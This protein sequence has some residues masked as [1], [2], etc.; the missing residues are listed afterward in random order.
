VLAQAA[1]VISVQAATVQGKVCMMVLLA[2]LARVP[3][4]QTLIVRTVP[5][6]EVSGWM[7][8]SIKQPAVIID[9]DGTVSDSEHMHLHTAEISR[10]EW[11]WFEYLIRHAP[12][13]PFA[14]I[15]VP[16]LGKHYTLIFITARDSSRR[17]QTEKWIE[18]KLGIDE[19]ILYMR[20]IGK[21]IPSAEFKRGV[22]DTYIKDNYRVKLALDDNPTC[23]SLWNSLQIPTF[24][25]CAGEQLNVFNSETS[26][27]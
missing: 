5:G 9:L 24:Q 25:V 20:T 18:T 11:G 12:V 16:A 23:I 26:K 15:L 22:Y 10:N 3:E 7:M 17:D 27:D 19:Y 6:K 13:F 14:E 1:S 8:K 21:E 4:R 2:T